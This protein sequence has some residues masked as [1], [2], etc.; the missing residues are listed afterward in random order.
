M[1]PVISKVLV[2]ISY[3]SVFIPIYFLFRK[4]NIFRLRQYWLFGILLLISAF[5]DLGSYVLAWY[6]I[7]NI[8]LINVYFIASFTVLS[9]I[10]ARLLRAV[11]F[12][13][14]SFT[15]FSI[16][17]F[18]VDSFYM[19]GIT[20]FQSYVQTLCGVLTLG[21]AVLYYD[22]VLNDFPL[23]NIKRHPFFWF[24]TAVAYYYS[25]NLFI[26]IFD[27]FIFENMDDTQILGVWIFHNLNNVVKNI[28][29]AVGI[30]YA[31]GK[32]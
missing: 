10:Y 11:K 7:P 12:Q 25:L 8:P 6:S 14:N 19:E 2:Y 9:L 31:G 27:T 24:N 1:L 4:K 28:L 20:N 16:I 29:F 23:I 3:L 32:R 30:N 5:A 22:H 18:I 13:I 15:I 21:Y 26:F 17:F